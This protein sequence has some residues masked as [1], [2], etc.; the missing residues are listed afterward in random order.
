MNFFL[1]VSAREKIARRKGGG[2]RTIYGNP[3]TTLR[4]RCGMA[5]LKGLFYSCSGYGFFRGRPGFLF[6]DASIAAFFW[7]MAGL[8][9]GYFAM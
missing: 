2:R 6:G 3:K 1:R 8:K 4:R 5:T 7:S 9:S